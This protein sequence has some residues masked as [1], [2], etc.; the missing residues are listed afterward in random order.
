MNIAKNMEAIFLA[1]VTL[2]GATTLATAAVPA[3]K[4]TVTAAVTTASA[5]KMPV[6]VI[7]AKRLSAA[8]KAALAN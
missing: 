2:A 5:G 4:H 3:V 6:V 1:A 7:T 8:E